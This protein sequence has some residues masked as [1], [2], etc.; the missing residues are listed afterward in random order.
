MNS[1]QALDKIM[2]ILNLTPQKF[3]DAKTEQGIAVKIDGDLELG[4]PIYVATEEGMIPAPAGVHKLD[5]GSEI[6]VDDD[7][8]VSKIKMGATPD[9]KMEDKKEKESSNI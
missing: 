9:A 7:G 3:Y 1:K 2:K 5:D 4:A 6:E 8:K